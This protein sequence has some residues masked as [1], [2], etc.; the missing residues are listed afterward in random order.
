MRKSS[1][2]IPPVNFEIIKVPHHGSSHNCGG[3][4]WDFFDATHIFITGYEEY[5]RPSRECL[6]KIISRPTEERRN[7]HYTRENENIRW[8]AS[9]P[10]IADILKFNLTLSSDYDFTF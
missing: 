10:E 7:I 2:I 6:A 9:N 4:F 8:L 3:R 5:K 1:E